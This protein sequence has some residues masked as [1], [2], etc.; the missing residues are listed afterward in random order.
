MDTGYPS[1]QTMP[2][3][4]LG[5]GKAL[6]RVPVKTSGVCVALLFALGF[7]EDWCFS[8]TLA[9]VAAL[10]IVSLIDAFLKRAIPLH[11][12]W[13]FRLRLGIA[14]LASAM[15]GANFPLSRN[16]AFDEAFGVA[17]PNGVR[18]FKLLRHYEGGP[19]EHTL[20]MQFYADEAIIREITSQRPFLQD[21][22]EIH[23]WVAEGAV[24]SDAFVR[25]SPPGRLPF[26]R[27]SWHRIS[28]VEAPRVFWWNEYGG[29]STLLLWDDGSGRAVVL[30]ARS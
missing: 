20:L 25:F 19:G 12:P 21:S 18:D 15:V 1:E 22:D 4:K 9:C 3:D 17:C 13:H 23:E 2:P 11:S 26:G 14:V 7:S 24:W 28:P 5:T 8:A 29:K 30:N 27:R 16:W 10:V 6:A